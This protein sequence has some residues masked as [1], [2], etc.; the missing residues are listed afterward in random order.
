MQF[1]ILDFGLKVQNGPCKML[2]ELEFFVKNE[3]LNDNGGYF[4]IL[5]VI[6]KPTKMALAEK[7]TDR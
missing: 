3:N 5:K 4:S 2:A 1:L 7:K 6:E